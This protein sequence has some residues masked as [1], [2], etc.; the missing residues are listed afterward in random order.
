MQ[1]FAETPLGNNDPKSLSRAK[2]SL[3]WPEWENA[4]GTELMQLHKMGTWQL[5]EKPPDVI[6]IMNKW[7][8]T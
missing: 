8:L 3:E 4:I 1:P 6:P 2:C 7:V 5:E